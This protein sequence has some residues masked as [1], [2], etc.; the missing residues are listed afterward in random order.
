LRRSAV[1]ASRSV[2]KNTAALAPRDSASRPSA[3]VP[4]KAS[5]TGLPANG[6]PDAANFPCDRM[7]NSASRARSLVGRTVSPGGATSRL[8]R[9]LP[10]TM[11][12]RPAGCV[13]PPELLVERL[14]RHL[15]DRAARQMAELE[16]PIG[17]TD[18]PCDRI[19]EMFENPAHLTVLP[20]LQR[21]GEPRVR[22]LL[23]FEPGADRAIRDAVHLDAA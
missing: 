10:P 14:A 16:R 19:A 18:Q 12:M 9:C 4:A 21:Q 15:L 22:A 5:S 20:L 1:N 2:S 8:P 23:A 6:R 7:L 13:A 17:Q 11:R 3:A